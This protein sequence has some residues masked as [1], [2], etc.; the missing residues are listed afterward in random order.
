[1][2]RY[3]DIFEQVGEARRLNTWEANLPEGRHQ[4]AL[5][6]YGPKVSAKDRSVFLEAEFIVLASNNVAVSPGARHSWPWFI[7]KPDEYGYTHA[8]AKDFLETVQRCISNDENVKQFGA[9]LAGDFESDS[10]QAYGIVLGVVV[11]GVDDAKGQRLRGRKGNEVFNAAWE[12]IVQGD[13]E[14]AATRERLAGMDLQAPKAKP[15]TPV[16][17]DAPMPGK[18]KLGGLSALRS[19]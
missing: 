3:D 4:V 16:A 8:R 6:K 9:A 11:T 7:N 14:I 12:S 18:K 15:R 10:P 5:V 19:V 13:D 2:S 17:Q 1:V